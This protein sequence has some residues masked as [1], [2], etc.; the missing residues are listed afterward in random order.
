MRHDDGGL[1]KLGWRLFVLLTL[2]GSLFYVTSPPAAHA[3]DSCGGVYDSCRAGCAA[4]YPGNTQ[5]YADC[6]SGCVDGG[7]FNGC[8]S[9]GD[10]TTCNS[11]FSTCREIINDGGDGGCF[12]AYAN[13]EYGVYDAMRSRYTR[14][15]GMPL[16]PD[17]P[18]LVN[19]RS[20][21]DA[22]VA[23]GNNLCTSPADGSVIVGCCEGERNKAF[24]ACY[25]NYG[26]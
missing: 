4:Q 11:L 14:L 12:D 6:L 2:T 5:A 25:G 7:E 18:C 16:E 24:A 19:A 26:P 17:D 21:Y 23:G 8:F 3:Y 22:C 1:R 20:D 15:Q 10:E 9:G 13:C